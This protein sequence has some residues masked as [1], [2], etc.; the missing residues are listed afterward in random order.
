[1]TLKTRK[2]LFYS[3]SLLFII[4]GTTAIFY[5]NGW[6]ID[7]ET[8]KI[9]KLGALFFEITPS[10]ATITIDGANFE[11]SPD[12]MRSGTLIANLFPKKYTAIVTKTGYQTWIKE[13]EVQPSLVTLASPVILL[14]EKINPG[15]PIN[16]N[17]DSFWLGPKYIAILDTNDSL[18][19]NSKPVIGNRVFKWSSDGEGVITVSENNYYAT[20]VNNPSESMNLSLMFKKLQNKKSADSSAI[21]DIKFSPIN[22]KQ[23]LV[24]TGKGIYTMDSEKLTLA[25]IYNGLAD[26]SELSGNEIIIASSGELFS[27][28]MASEVKSILINQKFERIKNVKISP[29]GYYISIIEENGRLNVLDRRS[30][31]I[32]LT[33]NNVVSSSFSPNDR[34]IAYYGPNNELSIYPLEQSTIYTSENPARF[35]LGPVNNEIIWRKESGHI[36]FKYSSGLYLLEANGLPPINMQLIDLNDEKYNYNADTN[37]VYILKNKNLYEVEL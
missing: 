23:F 16:K 33:D 30:L 15:L 13:L 18:K 36:L 12:F 11:F 22:K 4:I 24:T 1:M 8:M 34:K 28:E 2:I 17:V 21:T 35:N 29:S 10:D 25:L 37:T 7:P 14:P 27:Y 9:N 3:L 31:K 5:S 26:Y 19:I 20:S 32:T 6:R